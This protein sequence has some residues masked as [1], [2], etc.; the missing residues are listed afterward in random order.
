MH[1]KRELGCLLLVLGTAP[2]LLAAQPDERQRQAELLLERVRTGEARQ[3]DDLVRDALTRLQQLAPDSAEGQLA[4][5]RLALREQDGARAEQWLQR[6]RAAAP[7]SPQLHQGEAL[8]RLS[9]PQG[10]Q[11]LQQARLLGAA[12]RRDEALVAYDALFAGHPPSLELALEYWQQRGAVDGQRPLAITYLQALDRQ[13]PGSAALRRQL[14]SLLFAESRDDE[15]IQVLRRMGSD[16]AARAA[17]MQREFDQLRERAPSRASAAA[18]QSF[19]EHYPDAPQRAEASAELQRQRALL[20]N[21]GWQAGQRGEALLEAGRNAEAAAQLQAALRAFPQDGGWHGALGLAQIRLGQ[22]EAAE[23]SLRNALRWDQDSRRID[24]WQDLQASNRYWMTLQRGSEALAAGR[25]DQA[26]ALYR[27]ARRQQPREVNALLGLSDVAQARGAGAE[28]ERLLLQA[29]TLEPGNEEVLRK[30]LVLYQQQSPDKARAWLDALPPAQQQRFAAQRRALQLDDLRRRGEAAQNARDWAQA[31]SLLGQAQTLDPDDPWLAYQLAASLREQ[32][33]HAE[34]DAAF[35]RLLARQGGNP[36]ARYAHGLHLAA[37]GRDASALN[38]LEAIPRGQWTAD[39][40]ALAERL[41]RRY[42][43]ARAEALRS[44]GQEPAAIA[45]L[46]REAGTAPLPQDDLLLIADWAQQRN[47]HREALRLYGQALQRDPAQADAR[48]GQIESWL[49]LG[50]TARARQALQQGEPQFAA[51]QINARRRLANAWAAVGEPERA[52]AQFA[53]LA[54]EQRAPDALLHRDHARLLAS[55]QPQRALDSYARAM[56]DAGLLAPG[57]SSL[58]DDRALTLAS[59]ARDEDDWLRRSLR[60]DVDSLYQRENPT[61]R[62]QHDYAWRSD[63]VTPGLSDLTTQTTIVQA[64][65]PLAG[66]QAFARVEQVDMD[67][68]RFDTDAAGLHTEGFGTC[69]FQGRDSSGSFQALA[70]C[71]GG[72]QRDSGAA[73]AVGWRNERLAVDFGRSPQG[74]EVGNWLGGVSYDWDYA[75]LGWSLTVSRRPL[76]NS[77]LSYAGAVDPR[78]GIRWGGVTANGAS[79]GLS[80]DQGGAH[81]VWAQVGQH[82]LRGKNV[83]DNQRTTLMAGYYYKLIDRA[84][85]RL[86]TGLTGIY[87]SYDKDLGD[88]YLG[89]G[90]YYSPQRYV[91]LGVP[92]SYAWRNADWSVLLE[93]SLSWSQARSDASERYPLH[94]LIA[95]PLA[96]LN[97]QSAPALFPLDNFATAGDRSSAVGYRVNAL[98]ERRLSDHWIVGAGLTLQRSEDYAPN[99]ALLYLRYSF[100]PWQGNLRMAPEPLIPYADFK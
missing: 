67:A 17:A 76:S 61:L 5:L 91:S 44:A 47:D 41:E 53:Q 24:K 36:T 84:D 99:H 57:A 13:Y 26:D 64:D 10:Q 90:G 71:A 2:F 93:G 72:G 85:Q 56:G 54:T 31:S 98:V 43:R 79:L 33:R 46:Q 78:T 42:L 27:Q 29:R 20:A 3:R 100:E 95:G 74:F 75:G 51:E 77:L 70:G 58:R 80:Y 23:R 50:D 1:K 65:W 21:P 38:S 83:A 37:S 87:W 68:G 9:Q 94:S 55:I 86:R 88:Y 96:E 82:W 16:P 40:H 66:G 11:L 39:M 12:G 8:L 49:A 30:L 32:Q 92:V 52:R 18:W 59:R 14:A 89:Q 7:N 81:G 62:V 48:L 63:D 60:S 15:A 19:L 4:A 6:L 35:A 34:S 25:I 69:N 22:R 73:F 97:G 45:L 28:A